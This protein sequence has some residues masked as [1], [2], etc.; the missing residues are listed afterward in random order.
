MGKALLSSLQK[1][2]SYNYSNNNNNYYFYLVAFYSSSIL[3]LLSIRSSIIIIIIQVAL[4]VLA[5]RALQQKIG[6]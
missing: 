6:R 5:F 3:L 1:R 4:G 2:N